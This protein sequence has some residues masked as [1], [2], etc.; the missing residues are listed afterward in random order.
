MNFMNFADL[1]IYTYNI[2]TGRSPPRYKSNK[3]NFNYI[4]KHNILIKMLILNF[5]K[6][7]SLI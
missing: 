6:T 2:M 7:C 3:K 4:R 1:N 5:I